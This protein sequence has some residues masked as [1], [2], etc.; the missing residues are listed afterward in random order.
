ME[1]FTVRVDPTSMGRLHNYFATDD[2]DTMHQSMELILLM[3]ADD[4]VYGEMWIKI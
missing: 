1:F 2:W 3:G 4:P